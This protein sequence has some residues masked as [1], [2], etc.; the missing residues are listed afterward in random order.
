M[1]HDDL[2]L[3]EFI[4]SSDDDQPVVEDIYVGYDS[5]L[6]LVVMIEHTDY[7]YP[8]YNGCTYALIKKE[9][10]YKLAKRLRASMSELPCIIQESSDGYDDIINP[11]FQQTR[12]CFYDILRRLSYEHCKYRLIHYNHP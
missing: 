12:D 6:N 1:K 10:A 11:N 2:F 9:N 3:L 4:F 7:D 8:H 5:Y